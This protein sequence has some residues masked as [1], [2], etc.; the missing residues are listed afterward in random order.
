MVP[1]L[2]AII[3]QTQ[4]QENQIVSDTNKDWSHYLI[5]SSKSEYKVSPAILG[6]RMYSDIKDNVIFSDP[7]YTF[8]Y[9]HSMVVRVSLKDHSE[10]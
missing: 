2:F 7:F 4:L 10:D 9:G 6:I 1:I 5:Q 8:P 3:W